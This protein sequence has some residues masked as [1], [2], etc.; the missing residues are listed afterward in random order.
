MKKLVRY[1]MMSVLALCLSM[2]AMQAAEAATVAL[3]P[4]INNVQGDEV[5]GQVYYKQAINAMKAQPGFEL[6]ENDKLTVAIEAAK[7]NGAV[8]SQAAL[9]KIAKDGGVDIVIAMQLDKLGSKPMHRT[10][11]R[12]IKLD[13]TGKAVAYNRLNGVFYAHN[14]RGDKVIDE[15]LTARWDW[16]HEEFGRTVRVEVGRALKAK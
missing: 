16:P 13:M 8:P 9:E 2:G 12:M 10:G 4:L 6:V 15:A 1:L 14:L 3:L 11:E 5:A 7:V